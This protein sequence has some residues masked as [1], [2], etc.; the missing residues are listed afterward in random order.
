MKKRLW[1]SLI[2]IVASILAA[3]ANPNAPAGSA[4][5]A[6]AN[7]PAAA[8]P[9]GAVS[10]FH[11]AWPYTVPPGGHYNTF[12]TDGMALGIYQNLMEPS[13]FMYKWADDSWIPVAGTEWKWVDD[14]T[15]EVKLIQG[16][17]WSDG[18]AFTSKDVVDTMSIYRLLNTTAWRDLKEV[19][20]VDDTT[21]QFIL[22]DPSN[23]MLRYLLRNAQIHASSVYGDYAKK[24]TDLVAAGKKPEDQE[25]KDLLAEFNKF[26][27]ADMVVLGPYKIDQT[28][29]TEAQMILNK[30]PTSYWADKVKFDR[31][32]N[33]N[34][35]TPVITPLVLSGDVDY[36]TH[37]FPP[38]TVKQFEEQGYRILRPPVHNGPVI[39]FNF[40][41]HPFEIKE[42]RQ[43]IA[44]A[45]DRTQNGKVAF[46]DSGVPVKYMTGMSD[47]FIDQWVTPEA[48]A[49]LNTYD[50]DP[51]K[52]EELLTS[53]N[54]KKGADGIWTDETGK[55][56]E[57]EFLF[58]A[59][60]ADWSGAAKNAC[61]Q[62]TAFGIKCTGRSIT[63]T[64][65]A[66]EINDG[67]FQ[68][69]SLNFGSGNPHPS[70]SYDQDFRFYNSAMSGNGDV[71]KPGQ[72]F[73]LK[74]KTDVL[75]DVD[76]NALI[77]ASS[78]GADVDAQ[79]DAISKLA[80]IYNETLPG[81][82]LWERHGNNP[83]PSKFAA[84]WLPDTDPIYQND[85]YGDSFVVIQI[86][87]GTLH[88]AAQK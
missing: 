54:F 53:I 82:P 57:V 49:K 42:F 45:I 34:G 51:K 7:T 84:G 70:F 66:T 12:V 21:V 14:K 28:S 85:P 50:L 24:V 30:V 67:K 39:G 69:A 64:Q 60:F 38:A 35:E 2:L 80:L 44:Y 61:E 68:I 19:K 72:S 41:I 18:S 78:K 23:I 77:D 71:T 43:A 4:P 52:A 86:L 16:A 73:D 25:W 79:K 76:I 11:P 29:I 10:E 32:V 75:G 8:A 13:L 81:V 3:C 9:A 31:L 36:A 46:G 47:N 88:G 27:P 87:D 65:F 15:L 48:K 6:G 62:L 58:Q 17:K 55:P 20:A 33:Y 5:A 26:R 22:I 56:I 1:L 59:E 40:K 74:Q 63:Y 83:V 37:G